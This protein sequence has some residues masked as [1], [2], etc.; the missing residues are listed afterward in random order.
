[1]AQIQQIISALVAH[2]VEFIVVGGVA[3]VLQGAPVTTQDLD[4][5]YS[6]AP[7]NPE[8]LLSALHTLAAVFRDDPRRLVPGPTYLATRGHKLLTT[9]FGDLDCLGSIE[10]STTYDDLIEQTDEM[11]SGGVRF[12]VL[13]LPRLI[14]VKAKLTRPKDQL[15]LIQLRGTLE[16][17]LKRR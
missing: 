8:R 4:I 1:L 16:E 2:E 3:A 10:D 9:R 12:N 17:R 13:S 7:P 14:E 6:L 5:V 15:M 11:E